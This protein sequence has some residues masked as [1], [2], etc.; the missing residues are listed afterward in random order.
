MENDTLI[1]RQEQFF[2]GEREE[3]GRKWVVPL[4]SNWTGIPDT[5]ETEV[6]EIP[7]YSALKAANSGA[8]RFNTEKYSSLY[9]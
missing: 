7:N 2:I 3:K 9:Q 4:N 1:I 5:L 8:L 6:L